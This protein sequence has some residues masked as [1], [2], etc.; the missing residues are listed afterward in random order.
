MSI[1]QFAIHLSFNGD[2]AEAF[3][4]YEKVLGGTLEGLMPYSATPAGAS[5]CEG[6]AQRILHGSLLCGG[7]RIMGADA[8]TDHPYEGSKGFSVSLSYPT[9]EE[10]RTV[11]E[12]LGEGGTILMPFGPTFWTPGFG[13]VKDRFGVSWMI[14]MEQQ[15]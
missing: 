11:F 9:L 5:V 8:V 12:A 15:A 13:V 7:L 6:E 2:C 14:G 1:S 3:H 10:A 4:H